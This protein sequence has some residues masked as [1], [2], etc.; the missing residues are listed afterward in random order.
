VIAID[1][2]VVF[3]IRG[4]RSLTRP[5]LRSLCLRP[6][7]L[8]QRAHNAFRAGSPIWC[9]KTYRYDAIHHLAL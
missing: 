9:R 6:K 7:L 1:H 4:Y 8:N 3:F 2:F 5:P